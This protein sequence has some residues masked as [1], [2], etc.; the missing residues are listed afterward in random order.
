[1]DSIV[2]DRE[3]FHADPDPDQTFHFG[4][5]PDPDPTPEFRTCWKICVFLYFYSQHCQFIL[6]YLSR[7]HHRC[8]NF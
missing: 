6:L 8:H 4:A 1:M 3:S 5:D 7:Q 2:V